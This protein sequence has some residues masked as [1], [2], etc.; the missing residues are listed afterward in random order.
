MGNARAPLSMFVLEE[1]VQIKE[2]LERF[3]LFMPRTTCVDL[4]FL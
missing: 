1:Q 3:M 2:V 4:G